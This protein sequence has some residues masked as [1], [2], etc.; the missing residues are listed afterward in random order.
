MKRNFVF[1]SY[2]DDWSVMENAPLAAQGLLGRMER[3]AVN[4]KPYGHV[5][6][7]NGDVIGVDGLA[8]LSN[9]TSEKISGYI[10]MMERRG[11]IGTSKNGAYVLHYLVRRNE[12][13]KKRAKS[14]KNGGT[15]TQ[16]K[17]REKPT[18]LKQEPKQVLKPIYLNNLNNKDYKFNGDVIK[19]NDED[20]NS[21]LELYG[22]TY[23]QFWKYLSS[24]DDYLYTLAPE[25]RRNWFVSTSKDIQRIGV[26]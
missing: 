21:W 12:T 22:G 5:T 19:L 6:W 2:I 10:L 18:L 7:P 11:V 15:V 3:L 13:S 25:K 20:F 14:G 24:S 9:E 8:I 4:G 1:Q 17:I 26:S 16:C 23:E